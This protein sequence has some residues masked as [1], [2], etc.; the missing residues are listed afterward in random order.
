MAKLTKKQLAVYNFIDEFIKEK[1]FAPSYRDICSGLNL[2]TPATVAEH[3]NN[4]VAIGALKK[5]EAGSPRSL[6]VVDI[7]H[8]ETVNLFKNKI[9]E[10]SL[11]ET[12]RSDLETLKKAA[13]ILDLDLE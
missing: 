9:L 13:D 10:F 12:K 4:L 11:D 7:R 1:G 2:K 8:T 3:V 5:G 6:E